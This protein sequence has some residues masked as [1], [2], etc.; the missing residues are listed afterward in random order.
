M[1]EE[2][3]LVAETVWAEPVYEETPPRPIEEGTQPEIAQ[4]ETAQPET[5]P[6]NVALEAEV[7]HPARFAWIMKL[8][9]IRMTIMEKM[10]R[11]L[12]WA[13]NFSV[14]ETY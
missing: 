1:P 4:P 10:I 12:G 11:L 3:Q 6:E 8:I 2:A 14:E 7:K 13:G 5:Q 9:F